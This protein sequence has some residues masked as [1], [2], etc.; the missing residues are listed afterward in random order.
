MLLV[1]PVTFADL[2]G[3]ERLA[4]ISGGSMTT[5]PA[6]RDHLS[7]LINR[8]QQSLRKEVTRYGDESYH[9]VLEDTDT[10]SIVGISGIDA[11]VGLNTPFYSYRLDEI[12]HASQDLQIHNRIPSLHLCQDYTGA[13]RLCTLFIDADYRTAENL[14]LLSRA[15][16]L[17]I[18]QHPERF[19]D[20]LIAE[21][22]GV[23]DDQNRSPFWECVGNH[24]FF[25]DFT[26]ANYLTGIN[27]KGFIA[28]LMPHYPLY[29]PL[30]PEAAREVIG[31]ARADMNPVVELLKTEGFGTS[32]YVD[33]FDAG[34]T[35]ETRTA[36]AKSVIQSQ[37]ST[38]L[39]C[40]A[41]HEGDTPLLV[42]NTLLT[43]FRCIQA[44][45]TQD[46][47]TIAALSAA[48]QLEAA[49]PQETDKTHAPNQT[50]TTQ[51]RTEPQTRC[52]V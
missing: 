17:F 5:L 23:A 8:T 35:L 1:R 29:V 28:E 27:S 3:L 51:I 47:D 20:R 26:R 49:P 6:N 50:D 13:A 34:P 19:S 43:H 30:L 2:P 33:I 52:V 7:D 32:R 42:S 11:C 4:V 10:G 31:V 24:F 12:V 21:I 39:Q 14:S 16:F 9:F 18:A 22:Q 45:A 15:R 40:L 44:Q 36:Y 41:T 48:L 37:L 25:M 46:A 38:G